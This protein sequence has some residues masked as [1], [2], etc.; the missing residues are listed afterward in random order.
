MTEHYI[1]LFNYNYLPQGL[2]MY[3]SLKKNFSNFCL[4]I[5]CMD[6]KVEKFFLKK[7]YKEIKLI[8]LKSIENKEL[9]KVKKKRKFIEYCWTLTP[10]LPSFLFKKEKTVK[11]VTYIDADI[12]FFKTPTKIIEEFKKSKK[13]IYITEHGFHKDKDYSKVSGRFCVQYM[14]FKKN[15]NCS[16]ILRWWQA[17]CIDWCHDYPDSGRLG[18]QKYLDQWPKLFKKYIH[19]S[20]NKKFF[21]G[22]WTFNR[23]NVN[24]KII[25]HFHGLKINNDK[26]F[27]FNSYGFTKLIL[28]KI[29]LPYFA[30]LKKTL[31]NIGFNF[32]QNKRNKMEFLIDNFKYAY[33]STLLNFKK[34]KNYIFNLR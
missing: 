17:K 8:P 32:R 6:K 2:T 14:I 31:L 23:F 26:V 34:R 19:I 12:F 20:K 4:W 30:A 5:V 24:D 10:F 27:I 29:Y 3:H 9:L 11:K 16:K 13:L 33:S 1:T 7:N 21:Q 25:Y 15:K 28:N 18:D 22:P